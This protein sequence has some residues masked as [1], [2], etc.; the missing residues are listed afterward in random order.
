MYK[1]VY[2]LKQWEISMMAIGNLIITIKEE[3]HETF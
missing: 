1:I 3:N 2:A